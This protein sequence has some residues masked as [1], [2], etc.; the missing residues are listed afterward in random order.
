VVEG[1]FEDTRWQDEAVSVVKDA[2]KDLRAMGSRPYK[3]HLLSGNVVEVSTPYLAPRSEGKTRIRKA[4]KLKRNHGSGMFPTVAALGVS[5][6]CS[7]ALMSDLARQVVESG[8]EEEA[9]QSL[10][11]RGIDLDV[12]IVWNLAN[13]FATDSMRIRD[14][15]LRSAAGDVGEFS[16]K[17]VVVAPDGGRIRMR[18][19]NKRG[20]IPKGKKRRGF[21]APWQ[22]PKVFTI[23]VIDSSGKRDREF[24]PVIDGTMGD[25]DDLIALMVGYLRLLG[26]QSAEKLVI[27]GD[28]AR[29]IWDR[30]GKII[31][32]VGIDPKK[33][34]AIVDF[35]HAVEHL[36]KFAEQKSGWSEQFRKQW[37]TKNRKLLR[38]G[39]V[40]EV[41]ATMK[42]LVDGRNAK[43]LRT[44]MLYFVKNASRMKY[45]WF[46]RCGFPIGSGAVESCIRRVVNLRMKSPCIY[47][48][49]GN[50][51][52]FLHLRSVFKS[53]RW[54]EMLMQ[55]LETHAQSVAA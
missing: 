28:G 18:K 6:H 22:E 42:G 17:R 23:Y 45:A 40:S 47:W 2:R 12:K 36:Q 39:K 3:V 29:W 54:D 38:K 27:I 9:R 20:K 34:T 46:K 19:A 4:R 24:L 41:I 53:G 35:Y 7:P 30:V 10:A 32:G 26:V 51:E 48:K 44:E 49:E 43:K 25:A 52:G 8:S 11:R 33:V 21:K 13:R 15:R 55:T 16:G 14:E 50:A 1:I 31:E 37:V 5:N